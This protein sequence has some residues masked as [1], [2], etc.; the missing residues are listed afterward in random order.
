MTEAE[1]HIQDAESEL[2]LL[3]A[4]LE[5]IEDGHHYCDSPQ[6]AKEIGRLAT[7]GTLGT[8]LLE[9]AQEYLRKAKDADRA[10]LAQSRRDPA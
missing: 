10:S 5:S 7:F 4:L 9:S 3:E 6:P 1:K 8:R 2:F